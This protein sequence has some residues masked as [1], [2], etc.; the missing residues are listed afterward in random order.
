MTAAWK[1]HRRSKAQTFAMQA[2][3]FLIISIGVFVIEIQ[4]SS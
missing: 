1:G 3:L 4:S 2:L